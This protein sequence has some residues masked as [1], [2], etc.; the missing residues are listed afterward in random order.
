MYPSGDEKRGGPR[1]SPLAVASAG[2][3]GARN[4]RLTSAVQLVALALVLQQAAVEVRL[5]HHPQGVRGGRGVHGGEVDVQAQLVVVR[6][7]LLQRAGHRRGFDQG[8]IAGGEQFLQPVQRG[9]VGGV[10]A[11]FGSRRDAGQLVFRVDDQRIQLRRESI[12]VRSRTQS[13]QVLVQPLL[14]QSCVADDVVDVHSNRLL[15]RGVKFSE[16]VPKN[17]ARIGLIQA[18]C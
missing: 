4:R 13:R 5:A 7:P 18:Y 1:F 8:A 15:F 6:G 16:P 2:A 11:D 12:A 14:A 10:D 9:V 3:A 17:D